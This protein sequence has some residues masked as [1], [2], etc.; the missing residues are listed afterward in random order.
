MATKR[1]SPAVEQEAEQFFGKELFTL[2]GD[3]RYQHGKSGNPTGRPPEPDGLTDMLAYQL[4]KADR[5]TLAR[6][7]INMAKRGDLKAIMYIYDRID[8]R[9]RQSVENK[10]A[11]DDPLLELW[12]QVYADDS[13]ALAGAA[14]RAI[15]GPVLEAEV[16][17]VTG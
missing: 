2:G 14:V 3:T 7:L 10:T 1:L 12:R 17:E 11:D 16:R 15:P 6:I 5:R 8:G 9:P 13:K 4:K